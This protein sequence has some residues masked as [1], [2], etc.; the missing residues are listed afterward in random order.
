MLQLDRSR[1]V[2]VRGQCLRLPNARDFCLTVRQPL[3]PTLVR[4][5][6]LTG[7]GRRR[8]PTARCS[9]LAARLLVG[10]TVIQLALAG[11]VLAASREDHILPAS[12]YTSE[13][14]RRLAATYAA[15]LSNLGASIYH[16][17]PWLEVHHHSIGFFKPKG[18]AADE[19]YLSI[20]VFVE[21]EASPWFASLGVDGRAS[22]MFSRYV[23][24]LLRRMAREPSLLADPAV[25]GFAVVIEWLKPAPARADGRPVHE[26]IAAFVERSVAADYLAAG[27]TGDLVARTR[28]LG[29]DGETPLGELRLSAWDD[30]FVATYKVKNYEVASG[31]RCH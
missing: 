17:L 11:G 2:T 28:V 16:C 4:D 27:H 7:A 23:G 18:A 5:L 29:F 13:K 6:R 25:G 26:T 15:A 3:R 19:R 21:Q 30:D 24:P 10:A 12:E 14:G 20:R 8:L 22:S 1:F 31:V 9:R